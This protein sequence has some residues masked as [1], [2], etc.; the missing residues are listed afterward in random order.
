MGGEEKGMHPLALP[1]QEEVHKDGH[2]KAFP[3]QQDDHLYTA[4]RSIGQSAEDHEGECSPT[5]EKWD[6]VT[7]CGKEHPLACCLIS[8]S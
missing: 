4:M 1:G 3:V 6:P 8:S 5:A 7:H 2:A